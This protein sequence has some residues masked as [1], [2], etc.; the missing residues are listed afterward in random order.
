MKVNVSGELPLRVCYF[1][2]YR[3]NYNR[4]Q[5]I[6]AGLRLN[7]VVVYECH[8]TLWHG[9]EDRVQ[10][11]SGG[12]LKPKFWGRIASVYW[13]LL[14]HFKQLDDFDVLVVGYPG[15]LDVILA[16]ILAWS[17]HKP[18]VWDIL[19]SIYLVAI[20]RGL[21]TNNRLSLILLHFLEGLALKLPDLLILDTSEYVRWFNQNYKVD[22]NRFRLIPTGADDRIFFPIPH[23]PKDNNYFRVLFAGTFIPNHGVKYIVEAARLLNDEQAITFELIGEGPDLEYAKQFVDRYQLKNV[24]FIKW[25]EKD[26]LVEHIRQA[27]V[28]LG[29]FGSTPQSLMTVQ[30]KIYETW[31]MERPLI[32]GDSPAIRQ[33]CKHGEHIYLCERANGRALSEA[34]IELWRNP[35]LRKQ[36]AQNGYRLFREQYT[37]M[38]NGKRFETYIRE[39]V[40]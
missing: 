8:E 28:C 22:P 6:I 18:L 40:G 1:G 20:E 9:I 4:N 17:K 14:K 2:T 30:N 39:L 33:V 13:R 19:M 23:D 35:S 29:A 26:A 12:W 25:I 34:I 10:I 21:E 15:Q 38:K 31:A 32:S 11:A 16:R 7:G 36:I 3:E 24:N 5:M 27:D 37:L